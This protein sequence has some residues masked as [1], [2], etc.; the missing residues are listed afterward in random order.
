VLTG[1]VYLLSV[2]PDDR[3]V[4]LAV[5]LS[6]RLL[7][8]LGESLLITGLLAWAIGATKTPGRVMVWVGVAMYS[9]LG[10][11]APAG[12]LVM[13]WAGFPSVALA[14]AALP[15]A[16]LVIAVLCPPVQPHA[17]PRP[18]FRTVLAA[19]TPSGAAMGFAQ[20]PFAAISMFLPLV[21]LIRGWQ[22]SGWALTGFGTAYVTTRLL[23]AT[24]PDSYGVRPVALGSLLVEAVGQGALWQATTP[25]WAV[26]GA[27][28]TG[29]GCSLVFPAL[30]V[31]AIR[32][33]SPANR[34]AALGGYVAFFDLALALAGPVLGVI[35]AW[36]SIGSVFAAGLVA[37]VVAAAATVIATAKEQSHELS[38]RSV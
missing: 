10:V 36:T 6:G 1:L 24:W 3:W 34:G 38:A 29:A 21:Y 26:I 33:V 22:G 30:G 12:V 19:V 5:I 18:A 17:G 28:L 13:R 35:G 11:G 32:Y 16:A 15:A 4:R 7:L 23:C 8:G 9:A 14:A 25:G 37:T 27:A 2:L 20:I 31:A